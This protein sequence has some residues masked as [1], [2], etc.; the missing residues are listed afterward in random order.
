[1][2]IGPDL[3]RASFGPCG[4]EIQ[5]RSQ[6]YFV[7]G[8]GTWGDANWAYIPTAQVFDRVKRTF[9]IS[10][11][12]MSTGRAIAACAILEN[13][14]LLIAAGGYVD[15]WVKTNSIE[16]LN[17][18][19]EAWTNARA[20]PTVNVLSADGFIFSWNPSKLYQYEPMRNEW[21]EIEDVPIDLSLIRSHYLLVDAAHSNVCPYK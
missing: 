10:P 20:M 6:I 21:R 7:G 2:V 18:S 15:G 1:M 13:E 11:S 16:I 19:S 12:Q 17:L 9:T 5:R 3:P 14:D 8:R 4:I